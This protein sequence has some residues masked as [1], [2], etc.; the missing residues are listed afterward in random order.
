MT[1]QSN[2]VK[3]IEYIDNLYVLVHKNIKAIYVVRL[4]TPIGFV[5]PLILEMWNPRDKYYTFTY[6]GETHIDI[7]KFCKLNN[8]KPASQQQVD[9]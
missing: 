7:A 8:I 5:P 1:I 6:A 2:T 3:K 9:R 4:K